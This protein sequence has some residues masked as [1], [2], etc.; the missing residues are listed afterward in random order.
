M[1]ASL[2]FLPQSM[3]GAPPR[4]V[5]IQAIKHADCTAF[6][7]SGARAEKFGLLSGRRP[8]R[9]FN[10]SSA[11]GHHFEG[12]GTNMGENMDEPDW[13]RL[14]R[15]L[16]MVAALTRR[17]L[18]DD[19]VKEATKDEGTFAQVSILKWLDA[20]PPRR[21]QDVAKFLRASAP[22]ATQILA[23]LQNKGLLK[24]R[25]NEKD[26]RALDLLPTP[27]ARVLVKRYEKAKEGRLE[28]IL[29]HLSRGR[30]ELLIRGLES[31]VAVLLEDRPTVSDVC[32]HCGVY[33]SPVCV[34]RQH[35][36]R[37]PTERDGMMGCA[38]IKGGKGV[39]VMPD[40]G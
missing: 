19:L 27:R 25:T 31:A 21:A 11:N 14:A 12:E 4:G 1:R 10:D 8:F 28:S 23:R 5:Q 20:V 33:E 2:L 22:A 7:V 9:V 26:R 35:G 18:E 17:V 38:D 13:K 32:L 29:R 37:C 30:R 39:P 15:G 24:V 6:T 34:M 16:H 3:I 40:E 36:I